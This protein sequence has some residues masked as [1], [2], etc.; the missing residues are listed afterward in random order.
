M[1]CSV[2]SALAKAAARA[3]KLAIEDAR[4]KTTDEDEH[5]L[6]KEEQET[7]KDRRLKDAKEKS[8]TDNYTIKT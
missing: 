3:A 1:S 8:R 7:K 5:P 6:V 2:Q 4:K